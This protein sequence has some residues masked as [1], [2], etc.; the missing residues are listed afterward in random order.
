[1]DVN[2]GRKIFLS[3]KGSD[4]DTVIDFRETLEELG[5]KPWLDDDA[6]PAGTLRERGLLQG[7]QA[8]CARRW[9]ARCNHA[10]AIAF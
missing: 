1:M 3:H 2:G 8:S 9:R 6:M 10:N 5:Y 7:M 4:K